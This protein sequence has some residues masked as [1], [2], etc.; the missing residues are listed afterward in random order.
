MSRLVNKFGNQLL[1]LVVP[2]QQASACAGPECW[3]EY[4]CTCRRRQCC[5]TWQNKLCCGSWS[6]LCCQ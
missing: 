6:G 5:I 2:Q 4:T 1:G 3:Y